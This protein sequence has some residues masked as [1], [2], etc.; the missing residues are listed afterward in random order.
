MGWLLTSNC[1]K[2]KLKRLAKSTKVEVEFIS[3][4]GRV[5]RNRW[6]GRFRI[7]SADDSLFATK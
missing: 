5:L 2:M 4:R 1:A 6:R 3:T 7:V